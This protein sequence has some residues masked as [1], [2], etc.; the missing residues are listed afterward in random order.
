MILFEHC[1]RLDATLCVIAERFDVAEQR[2]AL[3]RAYEDGV[4]HPGRD[5]VTYL[6]PDVSMGDVAISDLFAAQA[7][8]AR[9][10]ARAGVRSVY[11]SVFVSAD[12]MLEHALATWNGMWPAT[13]G[14]A[15]PPDVFSAKTLAKAGALMGL[16][17]LP[18]AFAPLLERAKARRRAGPLGEGPGRVEA[19]GGREGEDLAR[20]L[21]SRRPNARTAPRATCRGSPRSSRR[22]APWSR[23]G[24]DSP[25]ARW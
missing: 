1:G 12:P 7:I 21:R 11:R 23:A 18:G 8:I 17:D 25:S 13:L 2:A 20:R 6:S 24:R 10:E 4:M 3:E 16:R 15:A 22:P 5:R 19:A 14:G 9:R